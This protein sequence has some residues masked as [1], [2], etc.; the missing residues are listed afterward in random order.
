MVVRVIATTSIGA[1][2]SR[3]AKILDEHLSLLLPRV[4]REDNVIFS[5]FE[6]KFKKSYASAA[7]SNI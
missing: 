1:S 6:E 5:K 3:V 4:I 7:T 2:M